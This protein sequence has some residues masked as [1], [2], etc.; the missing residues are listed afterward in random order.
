[1]RL[2]HINGHDFMGHDDLKIDIPEHGIVLVTGPNGSGKSSFIEAPAVAIHG[3]TLRG[4]PPWRSKKAFIEVDAENY[5][6]RRTCKGARNVVDITRTDANGA[7]TVGDF[8]TATKAQA[9]LTNAFG[10]FEVWRK[11]HVFSSQDVAHFTLS[12]DAERK[13]LLEGLL[14]LGHFDGAHTQCKADLKA[15]LAIE[16]TQERKA[17]MLALSVDRMI[18]ERKRLA[19]QLEDV[20]DTI[21]KSLD[22]AALEAEVLILDRELTKTNEAIEQV[23]TNVSTRNAQKDVLTRKLSRLSVLECP[24]CEQPIGDE[25]RQAVQGDIETLDSDGKKYAELAK[26]DYAA[27]KA[28]AEEIKAELATLRHTISTARAE[29]AAATRAIRLKTQIEL[30]HAKVSTDLREAMASLEDAQDA[31]QDAQSEAGVLKACE[32]VLGL[33]GVRAHVLGRTLSG[34]EAVANSWLSRIAGDDLTLSL[35]PYTEKKSGGTS[36]SISLE[37]EGAGGGYGYKASSGGERRRIDVAILLALADVAGA[38]HGIEGGTLF[39]D[40]VFDSL[41]SEGVDR[42]IDAV[43]ELSETRA[44][45][46]ISH[47]EDLVSRLNPTEHFNLEPYKL[48]N[49]KKRLGK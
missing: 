35:K 15:A 28:R 4:T 43:R 48:R 10:E 33:K 44:V 18:D 8:D 46:I 29:E 9:W 7:D 37:V 41:D 30:Q 3:K 12:T 17:E 25:L 26:Q 2:S 31:L 32:R 39:F 14:D 11:T 47:N 49:A 20:Q 34:V 19:E 13:R 6:I 21:A 23:R 42:V 22:V 45:L 16:A 24:T 40:E 1:M 5:T 38:A 27:R 36:E